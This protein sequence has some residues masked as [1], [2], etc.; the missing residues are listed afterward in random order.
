MIFMVRKFRRRNVDSYFSFS[1]LAGPW[2]DDELMIDSKERGLDV[3]G[4]IGL[5]IS[6]SE[7][8][9]RS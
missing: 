5:F 8:P 4:M 7:L 3:F 9:T 6:S 1:L 2:D